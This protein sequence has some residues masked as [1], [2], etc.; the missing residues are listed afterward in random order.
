M[1]KLSYEDIID[2]YEGKTCGMS[3]NDLSTKYKIIKQM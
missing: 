1:S 2:L 3:Y